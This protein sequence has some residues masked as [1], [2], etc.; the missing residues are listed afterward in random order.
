[1]DRTLLHSSIFV[2]QQALFVLNPE[3]FLSSRYPNQFFLMVEED[4][5]STQKF[6]YP[7]NP[8][9]LFAVWLIWTYHH[10][11]KNYWFWLVRLRLKE[12]EEQKR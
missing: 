7:Q 11:I 12:S 8:V 2:H 6:D 5:V 9:F 3:H 10:S 4:F 1:M